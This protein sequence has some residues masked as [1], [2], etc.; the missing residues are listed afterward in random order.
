MRHSHPTPAAPTE[1]PYS[2]YLEQ[3]KAELA[4]A[5]ALGDIPHANPDQLARMADCLAQLNRDADRSMGRER[6]L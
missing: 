2:L 4:E 5:R 3:A 6:G 1:A